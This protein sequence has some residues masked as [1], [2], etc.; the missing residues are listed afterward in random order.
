MSSNT[1]DKYWER[2]HGFISEHPID[3]RYILRHPNDDKAW[4][5]LRVIGYDPKLGFLPPGY[6]KAFASFVVS[7]RPKT[8]EEIKKS[9]DDYQM[10]TIELEVYSVDEH[11]ET[12]ELEYQAPKR[13]IEEMYNIKIFKK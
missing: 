2:L 3:A 7:R 8:E 6:L 4:G 5:S 13:E 1:N 9:L 10:E 11:V 12:K